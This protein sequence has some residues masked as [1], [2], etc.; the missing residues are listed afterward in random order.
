MER[1]LVEFESGR[2]ILTENELVEFIKTAVV[3]NKDVGV[4][5]IGRII[6][7]DVDEHGNTSYVCA[8]H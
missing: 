6:D 8:D 3:K 4:L 5:T 2:K 7:V 1:Y